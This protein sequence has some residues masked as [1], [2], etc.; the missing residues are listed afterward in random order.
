MTLLFDNIL[1]EKNIPVIYID[2]SVSAFDNNDILLL[3]DLIQNKKNKDPDISLMKYTDFYNI[4]CTNQDYTYI[5]NLNNNSMTCFDCNLSHLGTLTEL[6]S[7]GRITKPELYSEQVKNIYF[8]NDIFLI[9]KSIIKFNYENKQIELN[10]NGFIDVNALIF[11]VKI[12][13]TKEKYKVDFESYTDENTSILVSVK[14]KFINNLLIDNNGHVES[15]NISRK[16]AKELNVKTTI[17][18]NEL[19]D[20]KTKVEHYN[21][22]KSLVEDTTFFLPSNEQI[23]EYEN[24]ALKMKQLYLTD[25]FRSLYF[26]TKIIAKELAFDAIQYNND[27]NNTCVDEKTL[28][29]ALTLFKTPVPDDYQKR[30]EFL[31]D[32]FTTQSMIIL[33][34]HFDILF[35]DK[36]LENFQNIRTGN[37]IINHILHPEIKINPKHKP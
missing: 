32:V 8:E 24:T 33:E 2:K 21:D 25:V 17:Q 31:I 7:Y 6:E 35:S 1:K 27:F 11:D 37:Q 15:L 26:S 18:K 10:K 3:K 29:L 12:N 13:N 5:Y 14:N 22:L 28:N 4:V 16:I 9:N 20:L 19:S 23:K 36:V 30:D 34:K